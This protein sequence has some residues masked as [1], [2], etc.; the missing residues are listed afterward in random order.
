[1]DK[2]TYSPGAFTH[3]WELLLESHKIHDFIQTKIC[4]LCYMT[5]LRYPI[6]IDPPPRLL[7][8]M[9]DFKLPT[10]F[11]AIENSLHLDKFIICPTIR[12]YSY[13]YL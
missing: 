6:E 12:L 10:P 11:L 4:W 8:L 9:P 3:P 1:M 2:P 5:Y 7:V 13:I